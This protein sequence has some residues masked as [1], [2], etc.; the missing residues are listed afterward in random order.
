MHSRP[1]HPTVNVKEQSTIEPTPEP[2]H[3]SEPLEDSI[4]VPPTRT[5]WINDDLASNCIE[6]TARFS[7]FIRKH[8]C[9]KCGQIFCSECSKY[10]G[11][12]DSNAQFN[13]SGYICRLCISCYQDFMLTLDGKV[14]SA[15]GLRDSPSSG[16]LNIVTQ[17]VEIAKDASNSV[18]SSLIVENNSPDQ[19]ESISPAVPSDWQW[20]TF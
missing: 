2:E 1:K 12:L 11:K 10:T 4:T 13:L 19:A 14:W 7:V 9:R 6:C 20:S 5:H 15:G 16:N 3:A 18:N 17:Q 8:H